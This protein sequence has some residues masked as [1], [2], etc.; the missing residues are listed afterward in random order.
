MAKKTLT[1]YMLRPHKD[2]SAIKFY[3]QAPVVVSA[4]ETR[5]LWN[6]KLGQFVS[7]RDT[8]TEIAGTSTGSACDIT[9]RTGLR[10]P[11]GVVYAVRVTPVRKL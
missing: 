6:P 9:E 5:Q 8:V 11:A 1:I 10:I 2:S 3:K 4:T 7:K